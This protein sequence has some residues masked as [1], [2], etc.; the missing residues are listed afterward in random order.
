M[1]VFATFLY[2]ASIYNIQTSSILSFAWYEESRLHLVLCC[3]QAGAGGGAA[4][5]GF[6]GGFRK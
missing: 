2:L 5:G 6:K 4:A 1:A 3:V